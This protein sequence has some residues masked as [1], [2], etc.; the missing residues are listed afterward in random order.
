MNKFILLFALLI[1]F[2]VLAIDHPISVKLVKKSGNNY[3]LKV[4]VPEGFGIQRDAPNRLLLGGQGVN[5][6]K[7]DLLFKGPIHHKKSEY[8]AYLDDMPLTLSGKG[9]IQID[10]RVYYC[11]FTKNI[12][13]PGKMHFEERVD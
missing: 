5:V 11:N 8:F 13:I 1:S 6:V 10:A 12:C 3:T 4:S 9:T 2:P 7:A